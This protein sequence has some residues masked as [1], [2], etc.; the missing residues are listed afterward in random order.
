[1]GSSLYKKPNEDIQWC[2]TCKQ[3]YNPKA[4]H[5]CIEVLVLENRE[6]LEKWLG[7]FSIVENS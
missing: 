3:Y 6:A 5:A 7:R 4:S 1:M 2:D